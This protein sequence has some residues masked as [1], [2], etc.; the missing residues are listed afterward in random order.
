MPEVVDLL[1]IIHSHK[2]EAY[3]VGGSVRDMILSREIL[4]WD[5]ATSAPPAIIMRLFKR[6]YPTGIKHGTVTVIHK[7]V[8]FEVTTFRGERG[9]SD[10]RHPDM[11]RFGVNI[12]ED[13][14]RRD[15]TINA[16]AYDPIDGRIIDTYNGLNDIKMKI[17]R[18]VNKP[19][20]RFSED[21]L[22][23]LRAIR[24]ATILNF[25]L[26]R[27]IL[28][29]IRATLDIFK[30]V[31][32]ERIREEILKMLSSKKPSRGIILMHKCGMLELLFPELINTINYRQNRWHKYDLFKHS[33]KVMDNLPP[34]DPELRLMGLLHDIAKPLCAS[35]DTEEATYYGHDLRGSEMVT[36]IFKRLKFSNKSI[37]RANLIISNHMVG[38]KRE[39]SDAAIR[40]LIRRMKGEVYNLIY[41]QR[42][43]IIARGTAVVSSLKLLDELE[44][45]IKKIDGESSALEINQLR[46]DGRDVMRIKNIPPSPEVGRILKKLMEMVIERPEL[47]E[48]KRLLRLIKEV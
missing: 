21:G 7:G 17:I 4:D 11:V 15:F 46:V 10:G 24:F 43:D 37:E 29:A 40:R 1:K 34:D 2:Y 42:A 47:N 18:T 6:S 5:V 14:S 9:Y 8:K 19:V 38:Y 20:D 33:L 41:F 26:N 48:R 32:I 12:N 25:A 23:P 36:E 3:L 30:K 44:E 35:G 16:I 22:R 13:L 39:W 27:N 31:S 28:P 45:R